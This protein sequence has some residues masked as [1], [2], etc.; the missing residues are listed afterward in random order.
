MSCFES[1]DDTP[2][3]KDVP[4]SRIKIYPDVICYDD[5][6]NMSMV[7]VCIALIFYIIIIPALA[8]RKMA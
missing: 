7:G 6:Y 5:Q 2:G 4:V 1:V 3:A 8:W